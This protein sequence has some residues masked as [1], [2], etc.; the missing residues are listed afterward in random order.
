MGIYD[1]HVAAVELARLGHTAG[2]GYDFHLVH[3]VLCVVC[4]PVCFTQ[5]IQTLLQ[6]FIV[7]GNAGWAGIFVTKYLSNQSKSG[8][9]RYSYY[10]AGPARSPAQT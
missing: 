1:L 3:Q 5:G 6:I 7:G 4:H 2:M 10:I 9:G 8:L